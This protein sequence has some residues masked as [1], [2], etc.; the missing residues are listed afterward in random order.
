MRYQELL[1]EYRS[2]LEQ[3][4]QIQRQLSNIPKGYL[5]VKKISGKEYHY[6]QYSHQGRKKSDYVAQAQVDALRAAIAQR[7][8]L[9][10]RQEELRKEQHR[11]ERAAAILDTSLSRLFFFWKQCAQ[12][13]AMPLEKRPEALSFAKAMTALEGLPARLETEQNLDRWAKGEVG[14]AEFYLP[15]L[16]G[17]RV[18]EGWQ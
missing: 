9:R 11:L 13:D 4:T 7:E 2:L 12:M 14:F 16:Q 3:D 6:L 18:V 17:Y 10:V 15:T 8:P 1:N 5:V